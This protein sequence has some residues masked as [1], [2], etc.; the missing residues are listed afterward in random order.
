VTETE[1]VPM[2]LR[3]QLM[4]LRLIWAAMLIGPLV[5]LVMLVGFILP[6]HAVPFNE[7][8]M[9]MMFMACMTILVTA[10]PIAYALRALTYGKKLEDGTIPVSRY[11]TGNIIFWAICEGLAFFALICVMLN[12]TM[13][14]F[15]WLALFV[16]ANQAVNFPIAGRMIPSGPR[17]IH[18]HPSV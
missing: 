15:V 1:Q 6:H 11:M 2:R 12:G 9:K 18:P 16:I 7:P 17:P 3:Q 5:F 14:P 4:A 8:R 10:L 13:T